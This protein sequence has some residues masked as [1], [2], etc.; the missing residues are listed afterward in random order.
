M[1]EAFAE[2][3]PEKAQKLYINV[4]YLKSQGKH[5]DAL[6]ILDEIIKKHDSVSFRA[7]KEATAIFLSFDHADG[8][9][10]E[11]TRYKTNVLEKQGRGNLEKAPTLS[12]DEIQYLLLSAQAHLI[13]KSTVT[14]ENLLKLVLR[15]DH[16][17]PEAL[18]LEAE[19]WFETKK[20]PESIRL[21]QSLFKRDFKPQQMLFA[22]AQA[23]NMIDEP[24]WAMTYVLDLQK[25][26]K[27]PELDA[28][29]DSTLRAIGARQIKTDHSIRFPETLFMRVAP[30]MVEKKIIDRALSSL[31]SDK[32]YLDRYIEPMTGVFTMEAV[33]IKLPHFYS[34][35]KGQFF[36]CALDIDYFK[37]I[38]DC[39]GHDVG[40]EAIKAFA[41]AL[42]E[43]F[44][45][46]V[47][48]NKK[49]D[50]FLWCFEGNE[51]DC[52]DKAIAFRRHI[53][54]KLRLVVN[55]TILKSPIIDA[56]NQQKVFMNW[57]MTCSQ[58][59]AEWERGKDLKKVWKEADNNA[60]EAKQP[61]IGRNAIFYK[62]KLLDKGPRPIQYNKTLI[63]HLNQV[64]VEKGFENWWSLIEK[65]S[66]E[67]R[68]DVLKTA[69]QTAD[70][71]IKQAAY[72]LDD[73]ENQ[74]DGTNGAKIA[75]E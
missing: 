7:Y 17:N 21:Y 26:M 9:I 35:T 3:N 55:E 41:R 69:G 73:D 31:K 44:P 37:S 42:Q 30:Q 74:G 67:M 51:R 60:Y 48:R 62:F 25:N 36:V 49:G 56:A 22:L 13:K 45:N 16:G 63:R 75:S 53:E 40:D 65:G 47:F 39:L 72:S 68:N 70:D 4:D 29:Y 33:E 38:N 59:V 2:G 14:A 58:G 57:D 43:Y 54:T 20:Y 27:D 28:L 66:F 61:K 71:E 18:E 5:Q 19:L 46:Q 34:K 50:E 52:L 23:H 24:E 32:N 1:T 8:A 64:A 12:Q 15:H 11:L 6:D 10:E